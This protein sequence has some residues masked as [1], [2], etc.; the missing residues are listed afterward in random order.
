MILSAC[1]AIEEN[2]VKSVTTKCHKNGALPDLTVGR[3]YWGKCRVSKCDKENLRL[4]GATRRHV[5]RREENE[6]DD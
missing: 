6:A 5:K 3:M 1:A 2:R 4:R